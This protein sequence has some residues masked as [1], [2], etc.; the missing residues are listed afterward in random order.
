MFTTKYFTCPSCHDNSPVRTYATDRVELEREL[1]ENFATRCKHCHKPGSVHVNHVRAAPNRV[2]T[3]VG[4]AAGVIATA[5]LWQI[6]FIAFASG[7][8]PVIIYTAQN[9]SAE[10]FNAY[11]L[12]ERKG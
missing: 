2:V 9:R 1:G 10:T 3:G 8:L 5:A 4:I 12:P 11:K 6:G 7:A